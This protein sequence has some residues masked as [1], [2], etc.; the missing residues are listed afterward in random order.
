MTQ[1]TTTSTDG[2]SV[3]HGSFTIERTYPAS[4]ERVFEAFSEY[5]QK[6]AWFAE[7]KGF[8][9]FEYTLDFQVGGREFARFRFGDGPDMTFDSL[10][11]DIVPNRRI[12]LGY[13]MTAAGVPFSASISS[14]ELETAAEGTRM[15][16]TEQCAFLDGR[17]GLEARRE[18]SIEL[19]EALAKQLEVA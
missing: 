8:E 17:D 9:V 18:G 6:R 14:T 3:S 1:G 11:M 7:G 12:V 19:L 5:S 15:L 10:F 16:Y 13:S 4:A 2:R